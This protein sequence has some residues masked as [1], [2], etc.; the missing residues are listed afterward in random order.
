[1]YRI[2]QLREDKKLSQRALAQKIGVSAK[3]VNFGIVYGQQAYG[4]SQSLEI[5]MAE[6][7]DMIDRSFEV[8]PGV[9]TSLDISL[10]RFDTVFPAAGSGNS[11]IQLTCDELAEYSRSLGWIDV[12]KGWQET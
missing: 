11:A 8:Y 10:Q 7:R 2:K 9:R 4:L 3:A 5:P 1:M 12:C 6:A